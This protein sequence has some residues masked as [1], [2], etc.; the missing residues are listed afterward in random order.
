MDAK[1]KNEFSAWIAMNFLTLAVT[2]VR[3]A[4]RGKRRELSWDDIPMA[5]CFFFTAI[6]AT[7]NITV[8][9]MDMSTWSELQLSYMTHSSY[10]AT[11]IALWMCR[12][13]IV[14]HLARLV[15]R[16]SWYR[17]GSAVGSF[18][19]TCMC[20][21]LVLATV[22]SCG[23]PV[24]KI[25][26]CATPWKTTTTTLVFHCVAM[27]WLMGWC[28]LIV[29]ATK[30]ATAFRHWLFAA[31]AVAAVALSFDIGHAA[32]LYAAETVGH[33][34]NHTALNATG[35]LNM[36]LPSLGANILA[37]MALK[38]PET[39]QNTL[40][41]HHGSDTDSVSSTEKK[42]APTAV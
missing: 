9:T 18:V 11:P 28:L 37:F 40:A 20:L 3:F 30:P 7:N 10:Q 24:P 29:L 5:L 12:V 42:P 22:F 41:A 35:N 36:I 1:T 2:S 15:P 31:I 39:D 19:M 27:P 14:V 32:N 4:L 8:I 17:K 25:L 33:A 16:A 38:W 26:G 6:A 13:S 23:V 21:A 34:A